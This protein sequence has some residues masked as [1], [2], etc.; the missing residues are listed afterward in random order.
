MLKLIG[1][2]FFKLR[3]RWMPYV[4]LLALLA[5]TMLPVVLDYSDY[6]SRYKSAIDKY[7]ELEDVIKEV[8][9][10]H[11][12]YSGTTVYIDHSDPENP[13]AISS[14][15]EWEKEHLVRQLSN[16]KES[17]VLP[18]AMDGIFSSIPGLGMFLAA[19]L[20]ASVI[21]TEYGWGTLR[22]TLAKGTS[23]NNYLTAK[24]LAISIAIIGGVLV[25]VLVGFIATVITSMLVHGGMEWGSFA[26][27]FFAPLGR[28]LLV[29]AVYM[30]MAAFFSVLLRSSAAGLAVVVAWLIGETIIASLLGGST[31]WLAEIP[32]YLIGNNTNELIYV[33]AMFNNADDIKPWW[34]SGGILLAYIVVFITAA[35]YFFR[36]QDLTA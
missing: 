6:Q 29:L 22:Q 16:A 10:G 24:L 21:G 27:H 15:E 19:F 18:W 17:L 32:N 2:E 34:Q 4:L 28:T 30:A 23:R 11:G 13:S 31:G 3:K 25:V 26:S 8:E 33:N 36:R 20:A 9:V 5:I 35:Y 14:D 12:D 7:P 1:A